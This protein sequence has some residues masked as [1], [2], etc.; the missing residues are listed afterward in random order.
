[1]IPRCTLIGMAKQR[2]DELLKRVTKIVYLIKKGTLLKATERCH[3][4]STEFA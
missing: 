2:I 4:Y 3:G 1:M